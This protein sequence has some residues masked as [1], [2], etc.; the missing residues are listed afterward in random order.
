MR[1]RLGSILRRW[2]IT[3]SPKIVPTLRR[4]RLTLSLFIIILVIGILTETLWGDNFPVFMQ[5]YVW[6][7]ST[8]QKGYIY[9]AWLGLFFSAEPMDF[10]GDIIIGAWC[11]STGIPTGYS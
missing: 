8:L 11:R 2:W 10:Y 6:D 3:L 7:L 1:F 4:V 5:R 9:A